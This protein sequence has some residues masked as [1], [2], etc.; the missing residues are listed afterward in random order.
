MAKITVFFKN[1]PI[2]TGHFEKGIVRIGRDET[3]DITIDSL[4]VAPAH[5][6]VIISENSCTIKQLNYDYPIIMNGEKIKE[7]DIK[8]NDIIS[9]GKHDIVFSTSETLQTFPALEEP[10]EANF[11]LFNAK[12]ND[13]S[14]PAANFQFLDGE[15][16]GKIIPIKKT[17][18]QIG[19]SGSGVIVITKRKEGYFVSVLEN[20]GT[21]TLNNKEINNDFLKLC[22]NDILIINNRSLQFFLS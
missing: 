7:A 6:V 19:R 15:N 12:S 3:N 2:H 20:M 14:L 22:H 21:I 1:K 17:I 5:A 16:I 18:L 13:P 9:L 10:T 8:N 4:A 11:N